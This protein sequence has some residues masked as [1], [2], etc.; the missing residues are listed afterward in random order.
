MER[1]K[2]FVLLGKS[3]VGKS[4]IFKE[5]MN[6]I[7]QNNDNIK[8]LKS[9]TTRPM[10]QEDRVNSEYNFVTKEYF[11]EAHRDNNLL[12][13]AVYD[14]KYGYWFYFTRREDFNIAEHDYIKIINPTGFSQIKDSLKNTCEIVSFEI[15]SDYNVRLDRAKNRR[16]GLSDEEIQRR[17]DADEKDFEHLETNYVIE[18]NG[19]QSPK[20]VAEIIYRWIKGS[21]KK[22]ISL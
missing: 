12:E 5:L 13:Y 10:R 8:L 20:E 1:Y 2:L 3:N 15:V 22:G 17:F 11:T 19:S 6:L 7:Q 16:D 9:C 18:N 4:T 21:N 14:T